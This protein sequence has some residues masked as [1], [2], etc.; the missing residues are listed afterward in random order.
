MF[1]HT[2][3]GDTGCDLGMQHAG[4]CQ[5]KGRKE[6]AKRRYQEFL[7][8]GRVQVARDIILSKRPSSHFGHSLEELEGIPVDEPVPEKESPNEAVNSIME[9]YRDDD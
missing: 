5:W 1:K 7:D 3:Q 2:L 9:K 4:P 6:A 8:S